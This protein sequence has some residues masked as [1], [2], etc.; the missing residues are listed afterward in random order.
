M[1]CKQQADNLSVHEIVVNVSRNLDM[2]F[3]VKHNF[4]CRDERGIVRG[5]GFVTHYKFSLVSSH[6]RYGTL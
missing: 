6:D 3:V 2:V 1:I 5:C 4:T